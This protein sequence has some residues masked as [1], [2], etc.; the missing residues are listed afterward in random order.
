MPRSQWMAVQRQIMAERNAWIIEG[1]LG[2][3]DAVE[4]RFRAADTIVFLD[5]S[6]P[7]CAWWAFRRSRERADF[8]L[9]LWQYHRKSRPFLMKAIADH[10]PHATLYLL[11]NPKEVRRFIMDVMRDLAQVGST[12][13]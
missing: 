10:A 13:Q 1:D 11:R 7:R 2:P 9:W 5:F 3:Y 6:L 12:S 4:V 8:W